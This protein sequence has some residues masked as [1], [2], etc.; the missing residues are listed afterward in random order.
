LRS[1]L[2]WRE[3]APTLALHESLVLWPLP[4]RLCLV[5]D[6]DSS[7][8]E[9]GAAFAQQL[10][11]L[12]AAIALPRRH[13]VASFA[14]LWF[15]GAHAA[16]AALVPGPLG[17]EH[18]NYLALVGPA[19]GAAHAVFAALPRGLGLAT[20]LSVLAVTVLGAAAHARS[21]QWHSAE[22]L[23]NDAVGKN[24][25]DAT[26]RL[27]RG[28]LREGHADEALA[29]FAEAVRLAPASARARARLAATLVSLRR[30][31]EALP[32]A[33]EAVAIDPHGAA[34]YA[35][36]GRIEASLGELEPAASAFARAIELG[37]ER[38]VERDLGDT[39]VRLGRFEDSLSHFRAAIERD[40]GDD[41]ARTGA[42]AAL[43][44]LGRARDALNYLEPAVES[45]PNP[46]YLVHFADA[47]WQLGDA[48]GALDAVSMAVRVDPS[49]P[50]SASRLA[51]M[52]AQSP[53]AER[54]DPA[55]ALR[56]ADAALKQ[57]GGSDPNLLD[58]RAAALAAAG[59]FADARA[60][61]ERAAGLAREVGDSAL[62]ESI[63][64]HA[65]SYARREPWR[66]P[67]RPFDPSP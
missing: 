3:S 40:P 8:L 21:E 17:A 13:R 61:A 29:D 38:G 23:W 33:R 35:A 11:L 41:D 12:G 15:L 59:R 4:A 5:H 51:W 7:R 25:R 56:I 55:R 48:G 46:R 9:L 32:Q 6:L 54:R 10:L 27:E 43:V 52:L 44:E 30:E 28:A 66:D 63:S 24:P 62:A 64:A 50:G 39:L 2:V 26:A 47:L 42:G 34:G 49:W 1:L 36:L 60:D 16:E 18:R 37:G 58:A 45:Q 67:P 19:L 57:A 65:Q 20:A 31:R 14:L 53:D 22:A